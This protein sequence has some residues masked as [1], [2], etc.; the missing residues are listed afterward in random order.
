V[1]IP[2]VDLLPRERDGDG[3]GSRPS[4]AFVPLWWLGNLMAWLG[5]G[6]WRDIA[7]RHERSQFQISGFFVL[8]NAFIA[9]GVATLAATGLAE[10]AFTDVVLYTIVWGMFVGAIDLLVARYVRDRGAGRRRIRLL[11]AGLMVRVAMAVVLGVVIAEFANLAI[12]KD[13]IEQ[14]LLIDN[15]HGIQQS[16]GAIDQAQGTLSQLTALRAKLD[17]DI[18][19]KQAAWSAANRL[20]ICERKPTPGCPTD[21]SITGVAG[22]GDQTTARQKQA[23]AAQA[24]L[25]AARKARSAVQAWV[26]GGQSLSLD[27]Q[28][29]RLEA[30]HSN[31]L[32]NAQI[33][34]SKDRG[35]DARWRAMDNYTLADPSALSL[36]LALILLLVGLDLV[37]LSA[38]LMRG[39]TGH[40]ERVLLRRALMTT[41]N[42]THHTKRAGELG[43]VITLDTLTRA[44]EVEKTRQS[45]T[46]ATDAVKLAACWAPSRVATTDPVLRR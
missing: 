5:G 7:D 35:I 28:I 45:T 34:G 42:T 32:Q 18:T 14:Q 9:W 33:V 12:F 4:T 27:D 43:D 1:T 17:Q 40:D 2:S 23:D 38:K 37:P 3:Y 16:Q 11:P 6:H 20:F 13:P 39:H 31:Q 8:L 21:G 10:V 46:T 44:A 24:Q 22:A 36:R 15:A 30:Q 19:D 25:D 26:P 29:A 41:R